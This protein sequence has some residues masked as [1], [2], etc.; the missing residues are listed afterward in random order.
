[1]NERAR[2]LCL[3]LFECFLNVA[4]TFSNYLDFLTSNVGIGIFILSFFHFFSSNALSCSPPICLAG[5]LGCLPLCYLLACLLVC[6]LFPIQISKRP[7]DGLL[8]TLFV[9]KMHF[10]HR[11]WLLML[12]LLGWLFFSVCVHVLCTVCTT[13]FYFFIKP[14]CRHLTQII[15]LGDLM[16]HFFY[17]LLLFIFSCSSH[18]AWVETLFFYCLWEVEE[19]KMQKWHN[20]DEYY[21]RASSSSSASATTSIITI[22][23]VAKAKQK[24]IEIKADI[25]EKLNSKEE[26]SVL[27]HIQKVPVL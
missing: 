17:Y 8:F 16:R 3:Y 23:T 4:F 12:L 1:M 15:Q 10:I 6:T 11:H 13:R 5:W 7:I 9:Q 21:L 20:D 25:F 27:Q 18:L 22:A 24:R 19:N 14:L 2:S 26:E